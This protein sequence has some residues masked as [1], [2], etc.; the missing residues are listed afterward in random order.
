MIHM[1]VLKELSFSKHETMWTSNDMNAGQ[2]KQLYWPSSFVENEALQGEQ[3]PFCVQSVTRKWIGMGTS[4]WKR[5]L[6]MCGTRCLF[7]CCNAVLLLVFFFSFA[8]DYKSNFMAA[9]AKSIALITG[10]NKG[11]GLETA[12]QL[13]KLGFKVLVGAR[14]QGLGVAATTTLQ[15]EGLDAIF[16]LIDV[17]NTQSIAAAATLVEKDFGRLDVLINNAG[18]LDYSKGKPEELTGDDARG[19]FEVNFFGTINVTHA[20]LPLLRKSSAPRIVNLSSILASHGCHEDPNSP[21]YGHLRTPYNAA[22]AALNMYTQNLS[23][24]LQGTNFKVNAAHPGWVQTDMG[25]PDAPLTTTEGA[26]TSV[27]LATLDADGPTGGFF[28]KKDRIAW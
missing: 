25:G 19:D 12:R 16:L 5:K 18:T 17:V 7:C 13:G 21:I 23:L 4:A 2:R 1:C 3:D 10:A 24:A 22:K 6:M 28:H 9:V 8:A 11:V 15:S 14:D 27:Y 26:E 20:F